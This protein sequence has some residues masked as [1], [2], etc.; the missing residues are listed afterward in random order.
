MASVESS[1]TSV[2]IKIPTIGIVVTI[3]CVVEV[4]KDSGYRVEIH[5]FDDYVSKGQITDLTRELL[6]SCFA[7]K[8][9]F[10]VKIYNQWYHVN[11]DTIIFEPRI[12]VCC[13]KVFSL[14]DSI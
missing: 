9:E 12:G 6:T 3:F 2:I 14:E 4:I 5:Y 11:P 7:N 8:M 1:I 13:F 10:K